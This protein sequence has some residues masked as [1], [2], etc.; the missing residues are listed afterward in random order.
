MSDEVVEDACFGCSDKAVSF[1]RWLNPDDGSWTLV[2]VCKN[3]EDESRTTQYE[4]VSVP[5]DEGM[6]EIT[7]QEVL[8]E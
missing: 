6:C 1:I 4:I 5:F 7:V 3:C 8:E 2:F